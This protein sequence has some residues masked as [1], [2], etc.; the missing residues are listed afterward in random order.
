MWFLDGYPFEV[1]K[2]KI[3]GSKVN[4]LRYESV[5]HVSRDYIEGGLLSTDKLV[6]FQTAI[7][8]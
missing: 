8:S 7:E 1:L 3:L 4:L 5:E 6:T 2:N